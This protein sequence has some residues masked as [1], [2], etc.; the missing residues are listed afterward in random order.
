MG[1]GVPGGAPG[2]ADGAEPRI[3]GVY[4]IEIYL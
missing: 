1:G 4:N 2:G 3:A